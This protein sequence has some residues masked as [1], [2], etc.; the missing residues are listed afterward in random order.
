MKEG[1]GGQRNGRKRKKENEER[2][3]RADRKQNRVNACLFSP[4]GHL[5]LF[6]KFT[7]DPLERQGKS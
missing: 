6:S 4:C 7:Q 5:F 2:E 1:T 3:N